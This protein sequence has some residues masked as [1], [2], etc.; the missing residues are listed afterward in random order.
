MTTGRKR[1]PA[2]TGLREHSAAE[3]DLIAQLQDALTAEQWEKLAS[4]YAERLQR[5]RRARTRTHPASACSA[6]SPTA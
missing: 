6:G 2:L 3:Q 5:D 4:R 1:T